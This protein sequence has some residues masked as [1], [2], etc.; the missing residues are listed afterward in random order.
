MWD[1]LFVL[2]VGLILALLLR[3]G[4]SVLPREEWIVFASRPIAKAS[5]GSWVAR[6]FNYMGVFAGG[7]VA[8]A[9]VVLFLL[10]GAIRMPSGF[11]AG[12]VVSAM[13]VCILASMRLARC[14]IPEWCP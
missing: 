4:F 3:W 9:L 2:T 5:D 8:V 14:S 11:S 6:N 1:Y 10:L 7:A 13:P 12:I